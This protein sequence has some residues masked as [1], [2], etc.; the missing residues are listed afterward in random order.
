[1]KKSLLIVLSVFS[2]VSF[3]VDLKQLDQVVKTE[4]SPTQTC[5]STSHQNTSDYSDKDLEKEKK[6]CA[7][8]L[9]NLGLCPK[10]TSSSAGIKVFDNS[11]NLSLNDFNQRFCI[12]KK[13]ADS[14]NEIELKSYGKFKHTMD[15]TYAQSNLTYY[16]MS[17]S[18]DAGRVPVSVLKTFGSKIHQQIAENAILNMKTLAMPTSQLIYQSWIN[19]QARYKSTDSKLRRGFVDEQRDVAVGV[20]VEKVEGDFVYSELDQFP[21]L[22]NLDQ[23]P[24]YKTVFSAQN[25]SDILGKNKFKNLKAAQTAVQMKDV[26][27]LIVMDTILNQSDRFGNIANQQVWY[28]AEN[29]ELKKKKADYDEKDKVLESQKSEM[30]LKNAILVKEMMLID[31]DAG[32][33]FESEFSK[34]KYVENMT[35]ISPRT[36]SKLLNL[37][38]NKDQFE[39]LMVHSLLVNPQAAQ[40]TEDNLIRVMNILIERC[41]SQK[42]KLDIDRDYLIGLKAAPEQALCE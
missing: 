6:L 23:T 13:P 14:K 42:L 25:I 31:N 12:S 17:R 33:I 39:Q 3:A 30:K 29:N 20:I 19:L 26:S 22:N 35:H 18:L 38:K 24:I 2:N 4:L 34:K 11:L 8:N 27:D 10:L 15:L 41:K 1:M 37:Y 36:Y 5:Y 40:K 9:E 32:L 7:L 21:D 16:H 28:Y